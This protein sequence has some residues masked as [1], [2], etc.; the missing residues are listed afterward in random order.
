[1][2]TLDST[3][4]LPSP[5]PTTSSRAMM[6]VT[7]TLRPRGGTVT[8]VM[9]TAE[10]RVPAMSAIFFVTEALIALVHSLTV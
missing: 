1:M 9:L 6:A 7:S 8:T 3:N 5:R 2:H 4:A 10:G